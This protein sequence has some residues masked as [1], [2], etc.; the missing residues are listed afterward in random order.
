MTLAPAILIICVC[1]LLAVG[2]TMLYSASSAQVG[3][4]YLLTQLTWCGLGLVAATVTA[5]VDYR[6]LKKLAWV[7]LGLAVVL[8][9][10]VLIPGIGVMRGGAR[11][12]FVLGFGSF[13]PSELAKLALIVAL[14]CYG[15]R[16]QRQMREFKR[17]LV[18]PGIFIGVVLA[19]IFVEPDRGTAI[20][21][22]GVCTVMLLIAGVRWLYLIPPVVLGAT[23]LGAA[24]WFDSVRRARILAFLYPELYKDGAGYQAWQ[25]MLALGS[26]HWTGLGLGN[27][28]QKLGFVPEHHTDFILAVIGE[29]W[30]LLATVGIVLAFVVLVLA[31]AC[32]AR[33]ARDTFGLLLGA[34]I[35]FLIGFQAFINVGVVTSS[36][37]NKGLPLPFVS[38][39]G[40]NLLILL[41]SVGLLLSIAR[42]TAEQPVERAAV[43]DSDVL[44]APQMS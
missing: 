19:L 39:G 31:G 13:Q 20:L 17:G 33:N 28:R 10:L 40:S 1:S 37:P 5:S 41:A 44:S 30:G 8:L 15:E 16:C 14:A 3:A 29:E 12:W 38:Y 26:G 2:L 6:R 24:L 11:R 36:L 21:L 43:L 23:A 34:G 42:R 35:T 32:I 4:R 18:V 9:V 7:L 27:G 22:A 25:A